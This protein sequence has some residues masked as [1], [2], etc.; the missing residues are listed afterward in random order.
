METKLF[1]VVA[2][3]ALVASVCSAPARQEATAR[4]EGPPAPGE[5]APSS[6][7]HEAPAPE[8]AAPAE[9]LAEHAELRSLAKTAGNLTVKFH[10][11][12]FKTIESGGYRKRQE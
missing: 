12:F 10:V 2:L 6:P 1:V 4:A 11:L 3:S 7:Q 8:G 5:E 9:E